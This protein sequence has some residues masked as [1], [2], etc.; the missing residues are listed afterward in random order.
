MEQ[1]EQ[2]P[3]E[4]ET[5]TETV[6]PGS[7]AC[8]ECPQ[9]F[10]PMP[11]GGHFRQL[12]IHTRKVHGWTEAKVDEHKAARGV[13]TGTVSH[14]KKTTS[15]KPTAGVNRE[16][17]RGAG[18]SAGAPPPPP[19]G[20]PKIEFDMGAKM[21]EFEKAKA[22]ILTNGNAIAV[23][24][25]PMLLG[26]PGDVIMTS[27]IA[28]PDGSVVPL[29]SVIMF[30]EGEASVLAMAAIFG[31]NPWLTNLLLKIAPPILSIAGGGVL[32]FHAYNA[33]KIGDE[34]RKA[35]KR[36]APPQPSSNGAGPP[37]FVDSPLASI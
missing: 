12:Y 2:G 18:D 10:A 31:D 8:P 11:S 23:G 32:C 9:T 21:A 20:A 22:W 37:P 3:T 17:R 33:F 34:Y 4:G 24:I 14:K 1:P 27:G 5:V 15:T 30:N 36:P 6:V 29:A 25:A 7:A 19:P 13:A 26:I 16:R 28:R 35:A